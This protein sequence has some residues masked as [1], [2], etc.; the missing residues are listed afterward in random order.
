MMRKDTGWAWSITIICLTLCL[1][2]AWMTHFPDSAMGPVD[3]EGFHLLA[4]NVLDGH[5][6]A[7]GWAAPF[8]PTAVRTPLYPLWLMLAYRGL[9]R[10]PAHIIWLQI[11]LEG[12]TTA[13]VMRIGR[14]IGGYN[15]GGL[16]GVLYA[17]NGTTQRFTG[18]L[19]SE[20]LLLPVCAAALLQTLRTL[21][22]PTRRRLFGA[23]VGWGA[24]LLIKP[25]V[26]FLAIAVGGLLTLRV[27]SRRE[28]VPASNCQACF[29]FYIARLSIFWGI[30]ALILFPWLVRNRL[31]FGRWM[32]SSAFAENVARVSA[33]A[34][35]A[36][37][38]DIPADPWTETW[39]YLY[40]QIVSQAGARYAWS[41]EVEVT[42]LPCEEQWTRQQQVAGVAQEIV[43]QNSRVWGATHVWGVMLSVL[44]PGHH[45]WY[46]VLTGRGW[47]TTGVVD[48]IWVRM[49]WALE[50]NAWGDAVHAFWQERVVRLPVA[51][52]WVWWA[53]FVGRLFVWGLCLRGGLRLRRN[54]WAGWLLAGTLLYFILL[55]GP[56]AHDRF[57]VPAVP[58]TVLLIAL[59][60]VRSTCFRND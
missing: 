55:P 16:A 18:Y 34:V 13:L 42:G 45:L 17:F 46:R 48:N 8:C 36:E 50:R 39:E 51:A 9:G 5:G 19:L 1:R 4:V 57:Y 10:D 54:P 3:A 30:L 28:S 23:A 29:A 59:N 31:V 38:N 44:D 47:E 15:V 37:V 7:I 58:V 32:L 26:Q 60:L 21:Q 6:F 52:A 14:D 41:P 25:N 53:L 11:L 12:L 43:W 22:H 49:A 2:V 35:L 56:I 24:A 27:L 33:V 20:T 40:G